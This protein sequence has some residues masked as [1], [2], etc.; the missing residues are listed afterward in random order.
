[1]NPG[2]T[3][4]P[5]AM[6]FPFV[7]AP[8]ADAVEPVKGHFLKEIGFKLHKVPAQEPHALDLN[9]VAI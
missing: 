3:S 5:H 8:V 4:D 1:M 9:G 6:F 7:L 2:A